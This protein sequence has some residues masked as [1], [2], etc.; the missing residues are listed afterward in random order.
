MNKSIILAMLVVM[1]STFYLLPAVAG[2][3]DTGMEV[4][5][6]SDIV[7]ENE[8]ITYIITITNN[9]N[10]ELQIKKFKIEPFWPDLEKDIALPINHTK[11]V[12]F[13]VSTNN[14]THGKHTVV[15]SALDANNE[16]KFHKS[17]YLLK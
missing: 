3:M 2:Q 9:K 8:D 5:T 10:M 1:F 14:M 7:S 17:G 4:I 11:T 12:S 15:V 13:T 6:S 16:I